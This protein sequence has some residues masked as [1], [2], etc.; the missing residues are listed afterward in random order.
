MTLPRIGYTIE[1]VANSE[2]VSV[3]TIRRWVREGR[4]PRP[5]KRGGTKGRC[6]WYGETLDALRA[7]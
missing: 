1:T 3:A 5:V 4:F 6:V 2:G 7:G